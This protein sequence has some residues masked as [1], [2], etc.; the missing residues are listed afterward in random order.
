MKT[1]DKNVHMKLISLFE[2]KTPR[3]TDQHV[4]YHL[5]KSFKT[6]IPG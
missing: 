6:N 5:K 2:R 1:D 3:N 4:L